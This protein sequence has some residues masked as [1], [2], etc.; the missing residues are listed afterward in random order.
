MTVAELIARL[1]EFPQDMLVLG[2]GYETGFDPIETVE[3][4]EVVKQKDP[5]W[6]D[7]EY[8]TPRNWDESTTKA[9]V[10]RKALLR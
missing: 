7:G 8:D 5:S 2:R 10:L 3:T 1:N 4:V 6:W 9:V